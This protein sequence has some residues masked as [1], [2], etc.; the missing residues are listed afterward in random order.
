MGRQQQETSSLMQRLMGA[1]QMLREKL[2]EASAAHQ[3]LCGRITDEWRGNERLQG[4]ISEGEKVML[5]HAANLNRQLSEAGEEQASLL[6][7]FQAATESQACLECE[8]QYETFATQQHCTHLVVA[9]AE[10]N[11][12]ATN[13]SVFKQSQQLISNGQEMGKGGLARLHGQVSTKNSVWLRGSLAD[14]E[15][16]AQLQHQCCFE[17]QRIKDLRKELAVEEAVRSQHLAQLEDAAAQIA[18]SGVK[19]HRS[20][21]DKTKMPALNASV[22]V[23]TNEDACI[24]VANQ[25]RNAMNLNQELEGK[26]IQCRR[27][28]AEECEAQDKLRREQEK[29]STLHAR[30]LQG[31]FEC[32]DRARELVESNE[33]QKTICCEIEDERTALRLERQSAHHKVQLVRL[34]LEKKRAELAH[35]KEA[36]RQLAAELQRKRGCFPR[37]KLDRCPA[38]KRR[39]STPSRQAPRVAGGARSANIT[40]TTKAPAIG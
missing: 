8:L 26:E 40:A 32:E 36:N 14:S 28:F 37:R 9:I 39:K 34:Q 6:K 23:C 19:L 4:A 27:V 33:Y 20:C 3:D 18:S 10:G 15:E 24:D 35:W 1:K 21:D 25:V 22:Y 17:A 16:Q 2:Q 11:P 5:A 30:V 38:T 29:L 12:P 7:K 31:Q 13:F